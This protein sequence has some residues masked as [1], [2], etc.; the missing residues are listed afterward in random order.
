MSV[1]INYR[2]TSTNLLVFAFVAVPVG[3][4]ASLLLW[5]Q[6]HGGLATREFAETFLVLW[7]SGVWYFGL[8][9]VLHQLLLL[10]AQRFFPGLSV[11]ALKAMSAPVLSLALILPRYWGGPVQELTSRD[12][13]SLGLTLAVYLVLMRVR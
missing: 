7:I 10:S 1:A 2:S 6:A 5:E 13:F 9:V 8:G 3:T 12:L 4:V 11:L